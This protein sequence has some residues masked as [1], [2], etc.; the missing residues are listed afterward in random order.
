MSR[1]ICFL[2]IR[3]D[4]E[5]AFFA[6]VSEGKRFDSRH[7]TQVFEFFFYSAGLRLA[8]ENNRLFASQQQISSLFPSRPYS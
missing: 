2:P 4:F 6:G 3:G 7:D 8:F 5:T 1:R